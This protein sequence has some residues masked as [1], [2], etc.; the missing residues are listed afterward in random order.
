M[1]GGADNYKIVTET[2]L[3]GAVLSGVT[4]GIITA[5]T[6]KVIK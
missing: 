1:A 5:R 2:S 4:S 3:I 6:V